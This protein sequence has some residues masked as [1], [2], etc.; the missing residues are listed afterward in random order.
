[1]VSTSGKNSAHQLAGFAEGG[2]SEGHALTLHLRNI[3][4]LITC[5]SVTHAVVWLKVLE[6]TINLDANKLLWCLTDIQHVQ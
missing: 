2:H 6:S 3:D 4:S 1:M 5:V